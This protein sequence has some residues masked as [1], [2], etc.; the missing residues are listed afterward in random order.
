MNELK[1]T[2]LVP[3]NPMAFLAAVG[4]VKAAAE[5]MPE[6]EWRL[7][8]QEADSPYTATL[9]TD[10]AGGLNRIANRLA[11]Y[12]AQTDNPWLTLER[13]LKGSAAEYMA[14]QRLA[15]DRRTCDYMAAL[16][17]A[18]DDAERLYQT[19]FRLV[20]GSG[21]QHFLPSIAGIIRDTSA[22]MIYRSLF[23]DWER[24][25][26][27]F[28]LRWD[29][30]GREP[31]A[32]RWDNPQNKGAVR[33]G[34]ASRLAIEALTLYPV[35][36]PFIGSAPDIM[37]PGWLDRKTFFYPLWDM[38]LTLDGIGSLIRLSDVRLVTHGA[39]GWDG[40]ATAHERLRA[41]SIR[42]VMA[43]QVESPSKYYRNFGWASPV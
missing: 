40:E 15:T 8:W 20:S 13:N 26:K 9:H 21:H 6:N 22:D 31:Y 42:Q 29:P 1:L 33:E 19:P 30:A 16:G 11:D 17:F 32:L 24:R 36:W 2:G 14:A 10:F 27:G 37:T 28:D 3:E 38:P 18:G 25:E 34:G 5:A 4:T 23:G 41:Y 7:A 35:A 43:A 39:T 12:L